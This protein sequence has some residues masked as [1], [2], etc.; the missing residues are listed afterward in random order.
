LHCRKVSK[1]QSCLVFGCT[2]PAQPEENKRGP[3]F[4]FQTEQ[5]SE[6]GVGRYENAIL[7][8]YPIKY[9]LVG[10]GLHRVIAHMHRIVPRKAQP[11][12]DNRG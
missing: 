9:R 7:A 4:A 3:A 12:S 11:F 2:L 8:Q 1:Q 6:V 10:F 5:C